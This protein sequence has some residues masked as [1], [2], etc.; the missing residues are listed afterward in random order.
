MKHNF[1]RINDI[2]ANCRTMNIHSYNF[3]SQEFEKDENY[4]FILNSIIANCR[5]FLLSNQIINKI[6]KQFDREVLEKG[7]G[8]ECV[9]ETISLP[10]DRMLICPAEKD[11]A[12][13]SSATSEWETLEEARLAVKDGASDFFKVDQAYLVSFDMEKL[14]VFIPVIPRSKKDNW[15]DDI[16]QNYMEEFLIEHYRFFYNKKFIVN[17]ISVRVYLF[18]TQLS[19]LV[20]ENLTFIDR[21][22]RIFKDYKGK[23]IINRK[24]SEVIY[25]KCPRDIEVEKNRP[26]VSHKLC[27]F[28]F[29]FEVMG[30]WR[31]IKGLGKNMFGEKNQTS[32]TWV[33]A[34]ERGPKDRPLKKQIRQ[35][36]AKI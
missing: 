20:I 31:R 21:T 9:F 11:V 8:F 35:L 10:F 13:F 6:D 5:P 3:N 1:N 16:V 32:R 30:H 15:Q 4:R 29:R 7:S 12:L 23:T 25:L 14:D 28:D 19:E 24:V 17:D 36:E 26:G 18:L 27:K 33:D 22:P 2:I 34:H